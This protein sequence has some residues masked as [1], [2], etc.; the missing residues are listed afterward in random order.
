MTDYRNYISVEDYLALHSS[1]GW[2]ELCKEQAQSGLDNSAYITACYENGHAVAMARI[3]WD[4]GYIAYLSDVLVSP[5]YQAHH[6]GSALVKQAIDF[7]KSQ[8][9]PGW[10]I[11]IVIVTS[12][13][14]EGFYKNFGFVERPNE[15]E[16]AGM[17]LWL[18]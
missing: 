17:H 5:H 16:G 2:P 14:K 11:K 3:I 10:K 1:V 4:R 9:K 6:I 12:K 15:T 18:E 8:L 7:V 13:G